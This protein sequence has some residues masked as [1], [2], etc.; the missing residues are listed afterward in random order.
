MKRKS[1]KVTKM[2]ASKTHGWGA[3]KKH[4]GAGSRAGRGMAGTGKR[5]DQKKS[6]INPSTYFGRHGFK[7]KVNR[8][9]YKTINLSDLQRRLEVLVADKSIEEKGGVF[10]I[11]LG[12]IGYEKL[13]GSGNVDVKL[14]IKVKE[15]SKSAIRKIEEAKGKV[16]VEIVVE[17][18]SSE[19]K[20]E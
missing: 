10:T 13:L 18:K 14:H 16:E 7:H 2:R 9:D 12:K 8:K 11:D 15:A 3:M 4:R 17:E 19:V 20:K 5:A 1:K 6:M